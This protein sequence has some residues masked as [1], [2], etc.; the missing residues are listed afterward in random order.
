MVAHIVTM[1]ERIKLLC[2]ADNG[3]ITNAVTCQAAVQSLLDYF[4]EHKSRF[5]VLDDHGELTKSLGTLHSVLRATEQLLTE[6]DDNSL[7]VSIV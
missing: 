4:E 2:I 7:H 5:I 3:T 1:A 6:Y